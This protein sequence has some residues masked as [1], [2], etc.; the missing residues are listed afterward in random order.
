MCAC[1]Y[2]YNLSF[3]LRAFF[4][5]YDFFF[6][7][8]IW[9]EIFPLACIFLQD[10]FVCC[11]RLLVIVCFLF[12][13][14]FIGLH[15]GCFV[16]SSLQGG[17]VSYVFVCFC[18]NFYNCVQNLSHRWH[19]WRE[20]HALLWRF[21]FFFVV[22]PFLVYCDSA[23]A[24]VARISCSNGFDP[25]S[26]PKCSIVCLRGRVCTSMDV[27]EEKNKW[28]KLFSFTLTLYQLI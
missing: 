17:G 21:R 13:P 27:R 18:F 10:Y 25:S 6:T 14:C 8:L 12:F 9:F 23:A 5:C 22:F 3:E 2:I 16:R 7:R 24:C 26:K 11:S 20:G 19:G 28:T 15:A 4:A 1:I